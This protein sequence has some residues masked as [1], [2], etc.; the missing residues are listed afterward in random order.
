MRIAALDDIIDSKRAAGPNAADTAEVVI[1]VE[2]SAEAC[3]PA[4]MLGGAVP[5]PDGALDAVRES[6][7]RAGSSDLAVLADRERHEHGE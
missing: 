2:E 3:L 1:A 7:A 4:V 6:M 5:F